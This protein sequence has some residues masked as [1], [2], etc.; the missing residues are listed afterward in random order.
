MQRHW[1]VALAAAGVLSL[2]GCATTGSTLGSGVGDRLV[3][4]PPYY[5]GRGLSEHVTVAHLP[6]RYQRGGAQEAMFDPADARG[7]PV[8]TLI[9]EMNAYLDSLGASV[10]VA[11]PAGGLPGTPPDVH[12]G[13]EQRHLGECDANSRDL[14]VQGKPWMKLAVGQP[15]WDWVP[16]LRGALDASEADAAL[17][18][19]LE[20][21]QY[22]THQRNLLGSKEVRL[23]TGYDAP[24]PWLTSLDQP[25]Q[26]LQL[27]GALVDRDGR[28]L[29]VGAEGMLAQRTNIVLSGLGAQE[30]IGRED[31]ERLRSARR[32]DLPG[33]PLVWQAALQNLVANLTDRPRL[34][35]K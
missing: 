25:V 32:E 10:R 22:W 11:A 34:A 29:R 14:A 20:V 24:L 30:L 1:R 8:A 4:E 17:L 6:I 28:A 27:T 26:V 13:C 23:G 21:G 35:M 16:G 31:V 5:A 3:D 19:T 2:G 7:T 9:S 15:S 18:V 12:F 33:R